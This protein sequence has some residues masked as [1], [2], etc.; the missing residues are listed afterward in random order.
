M[1]SRP[2]W[3]PT[4]AAYMPRPASAA[5]LPLPGSLVEMRG[6]AR[7]GAGPSALGRPLKL[8]A[9]DGTPGSFTLFDLAEGEEEDAGSD[10]D[11]A[12]ADSVLPKAPLGLAAL[13]PGGAGGAGLAA[14]AA[15][16]WQQQQQLGQGGRRLVLRP[17]GGWGLW[18]AEEAELARDGLLALQGVHSALVRLQAALAAPAVL[19]RRAAAGLVAQLVVAGEVRQRLQ[20]F[21]GMLSPHVVGGSSGIS[22]GGIG[23]SGWG[24]RGELASAE[25]LP[26]PVAHALAAA[27]GEV[28]RQQAAALQ[29]LE[30]QHGVPWVEEVVDIGG[31]EGAAAGT[32]AAAVRPGSRGGGGG[33]SGGA[34]CGRRF[35]RPS[36]TL[37]QVVL[38]TG[39]LQRQLAS[40]AELCWCQLDRD[41]SSISSS[42]GTTTSSSGGAGE[43]VCRW[44]ADGFPSGTALLSY[45]YS[46]VQQ[47]QEADAAMVRHL[48]EAAVQPYLRHLA[49]WAFTTQVG[50][51]L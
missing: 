18:S 51:T 39:R 49:A 22:G 1:S 47:A 3:N 15:G 35:H 31:G 36:L 24:A 50:R 38:H 13:G 2:A 4:A 7:R 26:D 10:A 19:P 17:G 20:R 9:M 29:L 6:D 30:Q 32:A 44:E 14:T 45:L 40:L 25:E 46:R 5:W 33:A 21:V 34:V 42:S 43:G 41:S 8:L 37:L 11:V 12:S 23:G 16:K 48:F 27:V 28:L